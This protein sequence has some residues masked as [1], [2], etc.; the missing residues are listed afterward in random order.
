MEPEHLMSLHFKTIIKNN[1][2]LMKKK[3]V[4]L[5]K[6]YKIQISDTNVPHR[7]ENRQKG[8]SVRR[9]II[10]FSVIAQI[11]ILMSV[12]TKNIF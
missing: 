12:K 5:L 6:K 4:T 2:M 11:E 8:N 10:L 3:S 7:C 9:I 1:P